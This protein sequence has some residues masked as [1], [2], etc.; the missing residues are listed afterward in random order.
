MDK[1]YKI[2]DLSGKL[3]YSFQFLFLTITSDKKP[4]CIV[5]IVHQEK[6]SWLLIFLAFPHVSHVVLLVPVVRYSFAYQLLIVAIKSVLETR[7][8]AKEDLSAGRSIELSLSIVASL[9]WICWPQTKAL[10]SP[11][12]SVKPPQGGETTMLLPYSVGMK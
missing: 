8:P 10:I 4:I 9:R 5:I 11:Y 12:Q 6:D 3:C 1:P 2:M 7:R